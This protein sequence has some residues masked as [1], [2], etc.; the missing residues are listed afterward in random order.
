VSLD[1]LKKGVCPNECG[2]LVFIKPHEILYLIPESLF[3]YIPVDAK[4]DHYGYIVAVCPKCGFI[5]TSGASREEEE[6]E[7]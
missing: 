1:L 2:D 5:L 7:P 6:D 3:D 4:D